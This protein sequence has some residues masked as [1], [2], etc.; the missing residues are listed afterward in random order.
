MAKG[1][2]FT[3]R[4]LQGRQAAN[5]EKALMEQAQREGRVYKPKKDPA[6]ESDYDPYAARDTNANRLIGSHTEAM[7]LEPPGTEPL[8]GA[9]P[10]AMPALKQSDNQPMINKIFEHANEVRSPNYNFDA[11]EPLFEKA[12]PNLTRDLVT[13]RSIASKL[14]QKPSLDDKLP[15]N[16]RA[17]PILENEREIGGKLADYVR[18]DPLEP[19]NFY[20]TGTVIQGLI[21]KAGLSPEQANAFMRDWAGQGAATSPRTA[22]PQNLRNAAYLLFRNAVGDRLTKA[23][24]KLE[25]EQ[26]LFGF[27]KT[28]NSNP[29]DKQGNPIKANLNRPG[30]AMMGMHTDL[31]EGFFNNTVDPLKNPK[32]YTFKENWSG[33]MADATADTHYIRSVL[34]AYNEIDPGGIPRGWFK[35]DEGYNAYRNNGAVFDTGVIDVGAIKD[36]LEGSTTGGRYSQTEYPIMQ[37]PTNVAAEELGL[38]PAEV[39]ERLWFARGHRTGLQSP[40]RAIPDLFNS[41]LEYTANV[42]GMPPDEVLKLFARHKIPLAEA[43]VSDVP[44][45]STVG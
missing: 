4:A 37:G 25:Q 1:F 19:T 38:Q 27:P 41:Q 31:G 6:Y 45:Y 44:G 18:S 2:S 24:Q 26:G 21:D 17:R 3:Q 12:D 15:A 22:T 30:F 11:K 8:P 7:P 32:P 43:E 40:R 16:E 9:N 5:K 39:Q 42:L 33:N 35:T 13:Q 34:D 28:H 10:L 20:A 29:L 36:G 23:Q 14:P